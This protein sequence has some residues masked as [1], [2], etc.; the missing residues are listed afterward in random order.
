MDAIRSIDIDTPLDLLIAET[1][2][3]QN[4]QALSDVK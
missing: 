2:L 1:I 3:R 4:L